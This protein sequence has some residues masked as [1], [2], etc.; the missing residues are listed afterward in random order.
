VQRLA[1][2]EETR[3]KGGWRGLSR[4]A[5]LTKKRHPSKGCS[6]MANFGGQSLDALLCQWR[7]AWLVL[8][9]TPN[10]LSTSFR[11]REP[12]QSQQPK[13]TLNQIHE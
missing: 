9:L 5:F 11:N 2:K 13:S 6:K 3:E 10:W 12:L 1:E 8:T 7:L 4:H